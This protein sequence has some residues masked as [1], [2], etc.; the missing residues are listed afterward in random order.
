MVTDR[1]DL[2][3]RLRN[4]PKDPSHQNAVNWAGMVISLYGGQGRQIDHLF[5]KVPDAL[6]EAGLRGDLQHCAELARLYEGDDLNVIVGKVLAAPAIYSWRNLAVARPELAQ[7]VQDKLVD[8]WGKGDAVRSPYGLNAHFLGEFL[9][10]TRDTNPLQLLHCLAGSD[11]SLLVDLTIRLPKRISLFTAVSLILLRS[12]DPIGELAARLCKARPEAVPVFETSLLNIGCMPTRFV[13][14]CAA[15]IPG[16][17]FDKIE[18]WCL[19][20]WDPFHRKHFCD[21]VK[22]ERGPLRDFLM[23][24]RI[25]E[26]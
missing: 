10:R 17:D 16:M 4:I 18:E 20:N 13:Q 8:I 3:E 19:A 14:V 24:E 12:K 7:L 23:V 26:M 9:E 15:G 2:P 1:E 11:D 21:A 6:L 5:R 22:R 25:M